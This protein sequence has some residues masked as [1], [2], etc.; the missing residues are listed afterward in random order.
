MNGEEAWSRVRGDLLRARDEVLISTWWWESN[1]EL[2]RDP[3]T[4]MTAS[5]AERWPNTILGTLEQIPAMRR[6]LVGQFWGQDSILAFLSSDSRVRAYAERTGDNFEFLGQANETEGIFWFEP[7]PFNFGDRV[8]AAHPET[9]SREFAAEQPIKSTIE[10]RT[11]DLTKWPVG[12]SMELAS[13]HQKF[14]VMDHDVAYIGGMNLRRVD[15]DTNEHRVFEPRRMLFSATT[16]Q[17]EAVAAKQAWPDTG[18]RKDYMM[19]IEGPAAQDA[20]D[21]FHERWS[22]LRETGVRYSSTTTD[23]AVVRD[24]AEREGGLQVQVTATLPEPFLEHAI[25]ETWLNAV[26]QARDYI[27]IEDQYFR[28]PMLVDAIIARMKEVPS[29]KLVVFTK[30]INEWTDPG[31]EWTY[32]TVAQLRAEVGERFSLFQ[33]RS[34]DWAVTWGIDET[35]AYFADID[36]HAK[37][38]IVDDIF[39]SVGSANKNNRGIV[40]EG[41]LNVAVL[42]ETFVK[43]ARRRILSAILPSDVV[44]DDTSDTWIEQLRSAAAYNDTVYRNWDAQGF[45]MSLDGT[46]LPADFLPKGFVYSLSFRDS[47]YC[48]IEDVSPDL[49]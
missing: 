30:P 7:L 22:Y 42:D 1:F 27:Y 36:L 40:Y 21:V 44:P 4:H 39:M 47:S 33:L 26:A 13:Y 2:V 35:E 24:I 18:P 12:T 28:I 17:R 29:L 14:M 43:Q 32:K 9:A 41:E 48:A 25:A 10:G 8:R 46:P 31:C 23:F 11:V 19:R 45:D 34:F 20:A 15:W 49:F 16:E 3:E 37:L 6:V 5:E 38:L